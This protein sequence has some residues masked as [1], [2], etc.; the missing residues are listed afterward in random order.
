[1]LVIEQGAGE[2]VGKTGQE[3]IP[4][5]DS[6]HQRQ[7]QSRGRMPDYGSR[8]GH[9]YDLGLAQKQADGDEANAEQHVPVDNLFR[10]HE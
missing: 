8:P 5:A 1:M 10:R 4:R 7:R 3:D 9:K 6:E 2:G